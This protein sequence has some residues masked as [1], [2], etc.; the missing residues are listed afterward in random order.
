MEVFHLVNS[1]GHLGGN[2]PSTKM[3]CSHGVSR[4]S[5]KKEIEISSFEE[6]HSLV[7]GA[8]GVRAIF[9]GVQDS[10]SHKL[11]PSIGRLSLKERGTSGFPSYEARIL[12]LFKEQAVA[13]L[14][15]PPISNIEWLALAQHH[16]LPTRLLDWTYNPLVALFFAVEKQHSGSSAVYIYRKTKIYNKA[17]IIVGS[18]NVDPFKLKKTI[19]F[20]P[21]HFTDRIRTQQGLFTVHA[22]PKIEFKHSNRITKVI[23]P[24]CIRDSLFATLSQYQIGYASLFPGL[25]GISRDIFLRAATKLIT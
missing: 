18:Q 3:L 12:S 2:F 11:I 8:V 23:I 15:R 25:D 1:I 21:S 9:R 7:T 14:D 20:R 22:D 24:N 19:V 4:L 13:Y 16:G 17:E 5:L 6:Y 10:S